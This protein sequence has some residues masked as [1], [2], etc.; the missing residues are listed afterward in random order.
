MLVLAMEG[1]M[2]CAAEMG[3]GG[4]TYMQ[5]FKTTG[6]GV[7]AITRLCL[8]NLKGCNVGITDGRN[9]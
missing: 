1:T 5:S 6:I 2:K 9:L 3:S 4:M 7:Q 8:G